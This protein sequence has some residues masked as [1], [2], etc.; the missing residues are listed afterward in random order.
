M[1]EL[2]MKVKQFFTITNKGLII[3]GG[4]LNCNIRQG[5]L[6]EVHTATDVIKTAIDEIKCYDKSLEKALSELSCGLGFYC[7]SDMVFRVEESLVNPY[8]PKEDLVKYLEFNDKGHEAQGVYIFREV[9]NDTFA[10]EGNKRDSD[11]DY[12]KPNFLFRHGSE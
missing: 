7:I 1:K 12:P 10:K 4:S 2:V 6:V 8:N 5:E 11:R 9:D 3:L